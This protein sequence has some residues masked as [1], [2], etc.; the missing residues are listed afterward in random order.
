LPD[1]NFT[2]IKFLAEKVHAHHWPPD[3]PKWNELTIKQVNDSLNNN[4]EKKQIVIKSDSIL[5]ENYEFTDIKKVGLTIPLFQK[6]STLIFEGC[7]EKLYAHVHITTKSKDYLE[8][9][10]KL[11]HWRSRYFPD[12][13]I[14]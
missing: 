6:Q 13:L 9:F 14:S 5:I 3:T 1:D 7:F 11:V 8:I 2:E 12:S 4:K 10:N